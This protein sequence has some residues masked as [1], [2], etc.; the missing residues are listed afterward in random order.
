MRKLV[1]F[2]EIPA[3]NFERA[4]DFYEKVLGLKMHVE[5]C[6]DEKMAFFPGGEGAVSKAKGFDPSASGVLISLSVDSIEQTLAVI[7]SNAGSVS[8][9]KTAILSDGK[10]WFA[11]F[12]DCEGNRI[13][14][15]QQS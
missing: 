14:L 5:A 10:G 1:S 2:F 6:D 8:I 12:N 15:N 7:E 11:V 4:V 3:S 9:P 13:G